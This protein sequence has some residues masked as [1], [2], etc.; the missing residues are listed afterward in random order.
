MN[1]NYPIYFSAGLTEKVSCQAD[2]S[3]VFPFY[4][5]LTIT[6]FLSTLVFLFPPTCLAV[7]VVVVVVVVIVIFISYLFQPTSPLTL[8]P[9]PCAPRLTTT[10]S[11]S[12]H[13]PIRRSAALSSRGTCLSSSTSRSGSWECTSLQILWVLFINGHEHLGRGG[14]GE[15]N[16]LSLARSQSYQLCVY[17]R[18]LRDSACH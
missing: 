4:L 5:L 9:G 1:L 7:V 14:W 17:P 10:T 6:S 12:S 2:L 11:C 8:S 15:R 3:T 18:E 16:Q 13:G